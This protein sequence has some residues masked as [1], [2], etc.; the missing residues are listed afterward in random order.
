MKKQFSGRLRAGLMFLCLFVLSTSCEYLK[1][2]EPHKNRSV[3]YGPEAALGQGTARAWI[4]MGPD[5]KPM[6]IGVDLSADA[7]DGLPDEV[8]MYHV[9]LPQQATMTPYKTIM[10]DWNPHGHDPE[11]VYGAPH[12]DLHFYMIGDEERQL[13]PAGEHGH[14]PEFQANYMPPTYFSTMMSVPEMG[15][16]WVDGMAPEITGA[17]PFTR[18]FIYGAY[19]DKVIFYEPMFTLDYLKHLPAG[20]QQKMAVP[21]PPKVQQ[22]GEHPLSYTITYRQNPGSYTIALTDLYYRKAK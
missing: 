16:H 18:T 11:E 14:S 22:S 6:A 7:L 8:K 1:D 9:Q 19:Q 10:I 4:R 13:I 17:E 2:Q 5:G 3:H 12:F 21:Q 15:V 20:K